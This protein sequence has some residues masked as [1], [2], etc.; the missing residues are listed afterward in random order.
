MTEL[1]RVERAQGWPLLKESGHQDPC[2]QVAVYG[3]KAKTEYHRQQE[4][5]ALPA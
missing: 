2:E 4:N 3:R 5:P 1:A